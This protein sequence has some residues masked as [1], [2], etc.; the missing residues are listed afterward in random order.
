MLSPSSDG[1]DERWTYH[2]EI[3]G[4][5]GDEEMKTKKTK[6]MR[7]KVCEGKEK[8]WTSMSFIP[9]PRDLPSPGPCTFKTWKL[10]D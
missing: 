8:D 7:M 9:V 4:R 3:R 5:E 1:L 10:N 6:R 2:D